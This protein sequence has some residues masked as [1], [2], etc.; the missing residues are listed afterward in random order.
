MRHV[1][2]AAAARQPATSSDSEAITVLQKFIVKGHPKFV[3]ASR[4]I[5][6]SE[7]FRS[8]HISATLPIG[9]HAAKAGVG[10]LQSRSRSVQCSVD[11]R[12]YKAHKTVSNLRP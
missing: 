4:L 12:A 9:A 8:K 11:R 7:R 5:L 2:R 10:Q 3:V 1:S 6:D